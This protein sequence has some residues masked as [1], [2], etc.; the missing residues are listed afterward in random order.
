MCLSSVTVGSS[1]TVSGNQFHVWNTIHPSIRGDKQA[2]CRDCANRREGGADVCGG[3]TDPSP[4]FN[5]RSGSGQIQTTSQIIIAHHHRQLCL[6]FVVPRPGGIRCVRTDTTDSLRVLFRRCDVLHVAEWNA[7]TASVS[8][9]V[10]VTQSDAMI[11]F[12]NGAPFFSLVVP[13]CS[14]SHRIRG[15]YLSW[16]SDKANSKGN[17]L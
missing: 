1:L 9:N 8:E 15:S 6:T 16:R 14:C 7:P 5:L 17:A 11:N 12:L 2:F 13:A 10:R 3:Y 4:L